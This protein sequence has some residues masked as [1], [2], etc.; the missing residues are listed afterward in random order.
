MWGKVKQFFW[1]SRGIWITAPTIAGVVILLRFSGL[2]QATE[3]ALF[4]QYMRLRPLEPRDERVAIVGIN[5][6]DVENLNTATISDEVYAELLDK[7]RAMKPRAIGLDIYRNLP[8]PPG[9]EKLVEVFET[10]PNLIGIRKVAGEKGRE[11]VPPPPALGKLGQV[12]ANDLVFDADD[13]LRRG[14]MSLTSP[15]GEI[16]YSFGLYLSLL[17]L[18]A[19]GIQ[20]ETLEENVFKLGKATFS[21]L[22]A[23][24]GGYVRTDDRAYQLLINYRGASQHFETVSMTDILEGNVPSDWAKDRVILIGKVGESFKDLFKTP[25]S[26]GLLASPEPV[27]G[28][29]VHANIVSQIISAA[30]E[31][32]PLFRSWSEPIE[33]V[34]ILF[35]SGVGATIS[36]KFRYIGGAKWLSWQT[37]LGPVV[38]GGVL[39]GVTF[40]LFLEGWWIPAIPPFLAMVG[41]VAAI[42]AYVAHTAGDIRKTFGRYLSDSIV[43]TLL[44]SPEGLKM[45]G[46][47]RK[48]TILTSDLRGFTATSERLPPE[49]VVKIL[50]LYLGYMADIITH[51]QGTIDEFMGDGILV[52]FGAPTS[53]PDDAKRA[54]ACAVAMQL[55]MEA[56]NE[57][58]QELELPKL[59][60]G[61]GINTGEVVVGNIGSEK[62]TKYGIV[63]SQVNLTYRIESYTTSGQIFISESTFQEAGNDVKIKGAKAVSPKGVKEPIT[64]YDVAGVAGEYNLLLPEDHEIFV[65]LKEEIPLKF[66]ILN[67]KDISD[68]VHVG[69][70]I[71][72]SEKGALISYQASESHDEFD[73]I[74]S[75]LTNLKI[76]FLPTPHELQISEDIYAKVTEKEAK[77]ANHFYIFFTAKPPEIEKMLESLYESVLE[78]KEKAKTA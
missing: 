38:A 8:E 13:R 9:H 59:Q 18:D 41:S 16:V 62:R 61:I 7:L 60:M 19:E 1:D 12:G 33:G 71:C 37:I 30:L 20:P 11:T 5:E 64:I 29:E 69:R 10:T 25:Y 36:W 56:V 4:D 77:E 2:L 54:V 46:E 17:Y 74:P 57:K 48:I 31:G 58:M 49:G 50:N 6:A 42:T 21:P 65:P 67:G 34:W 28:V 23:N 78:E 55:A 68:R 14:L 22:K 52:L 35:W 47:R 44:E 27:A 53:R 43:T 45:G 72:L 70:M 73:S 24:D 3:W 75:A 26:S 51:Y 66:S 32:R 39:F 40:V 15:D 76:N 63:G